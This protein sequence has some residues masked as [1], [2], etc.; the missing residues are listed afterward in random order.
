[1]KKIDDKTQSDL[2]ECIEELKSASDEYSAGVEEAN[3]AIHELNNK[4][5]ELNENHNDRVH[6]LK[7][8]IEK[9]IAKQESHIKKQ[10]EKW[11]TTLEGEA[12]NEWYQSWK[13]YLGEV[14]D[15]SLD[16]TKIEAVSDASYDPYDAIVPAWEP[17]ETT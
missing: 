16:D 11:A 2:D 7:N 12:Y 13:D 1:M 4:L 3:E 6:S 14:Q 15:F 10:D 17:D 8:R 9:I 5:A